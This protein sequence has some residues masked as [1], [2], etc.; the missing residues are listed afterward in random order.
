MIGALLAAAAAAAPLAWR[1]PEEGLSYRL[2]AEL[3]FAEPVA[4]ELGE[5]APRVS[6]LRLV[7]R[8]WCIPEDRALRCELRDARLQLETSRAAYGPANGVLSHLQRAIDGSAVTLRVG[9]RGALRR[10]GA[11]ACGGD[12]QTEAL[13]EALL[14]TS[15]WGLD[16]QA[17]ADPEA[18]HW[19]QRPLL[20]DLDAELE[21]RRDGPP[22]PPG[23]Q[24]VLID[25]GGRDRVAGQYVFDTDRG[26]V[27][28]AE[29]EVELAEPGGGLIS[30]SA[31]E[32][33]P[34]ARRAA[35]TWMKRGGDGAP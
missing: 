1:W 31:A 22:E 12:S 33:Y 8:A 17:P 11:A 34:S 2:E 21:H 26:W 15:F 7:T 30:L 20:M 28:S 14:E 27:R 10:I 24:R 16:I 13:C 5:D 25:G 4:M 32:V 9:E 6:A 29:L 3:D 35:A 18:D 19:S 23:R